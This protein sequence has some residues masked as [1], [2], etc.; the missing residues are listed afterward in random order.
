MPKMILEIPGS[1]TDLAQNW[2]FLNYNC[3]VDVVML[4]SILPVI[5]TE[6]MCCEKNFPIGETQFSEIL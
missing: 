6:C 4:P 5:G 1:V 3:K 2:H